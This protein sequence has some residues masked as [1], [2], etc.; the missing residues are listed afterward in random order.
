M[1]A[2]VLKELAGAIGITVAGSLI[3]TLAY[4]ALLGCVMASQRQRSLRYAWWR[5]FLL[6]LAGITGWLYLSGLAGSVTG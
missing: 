6:T 3:G 5:G 1:N 2:Y 4:V